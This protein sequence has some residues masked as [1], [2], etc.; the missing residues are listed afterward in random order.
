MEEFRGC[1]FKIFASFKGQF[2]LEQAS[3]TY[4]VRAGH[5]IWHC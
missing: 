2:Y 3:C 1:P 4:L 5:F